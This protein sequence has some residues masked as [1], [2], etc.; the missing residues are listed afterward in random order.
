VSV[1]GPGS[2][3]NF[4]ARRTLVVPDPSVLATHWS[5]PADPS[6][7]TGFDTSPRLK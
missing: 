5:S 6:R 1:A 3:L 7:Q 4:P 2:L